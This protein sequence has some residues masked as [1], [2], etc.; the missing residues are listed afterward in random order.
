RCTNLP[1]G[2]PS[3]IGTSAA[4]HDRAYNL[5]TLSRRDERSRCPGAGSEVTNEEVRYLGVCREPVGDADKPV[6]EKADI[7]TDLRRMQV[8]SFLVRCQQIYQ[9]GRKL[10]LIEQFCYVTISR[11]VSTTPTTVSE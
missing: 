4:R 1:Q 11:A 6:G 2:R 8:D 10:P 5:R 7:K 9:Q 3:Q